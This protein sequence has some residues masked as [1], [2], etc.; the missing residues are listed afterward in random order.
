MKKITGKL[1]E[2]T[3]I[4]VIISRLFL[5]RTRNISDKNC[6]EIQTTFYVQ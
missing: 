2:N 1:H 3:L 4:F 6:R 5:L